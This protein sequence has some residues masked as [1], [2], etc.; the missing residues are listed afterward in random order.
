MASFPESPIERHHHEPPSHIPIYYIILLKSFP[1]AGGLV[2]HF[3]RA[4][5]T[6]EFERLEMAPKCVNPAPETPH[7]YY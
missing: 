5:R 3:E 1:V 7:L 2:Q 4:F 6:P